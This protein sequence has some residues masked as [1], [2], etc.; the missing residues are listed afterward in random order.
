ME[1]YDNDTGL[2]G[3]TLAS[4]AEVTRVKSETS[5]FAVTASGSYK[6][7]ALGTNSSVRRLTTFLEG[8][9]GL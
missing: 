6:M 7:D 9:A 4:P 3:D 1:G 5:E 2:A 8:S